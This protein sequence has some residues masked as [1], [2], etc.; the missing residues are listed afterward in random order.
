MHLL[1]DTR[2]YLAPD[3]LV[4]LRVRGNDV[5]RAHDWPALH[6]LAPQLRR[7][8]S[9]WP[10]TWG[11]LCAVAAREVGDPGAR[12]LLEE[13]IAAGFHQPELYADVLESAFG[14]DPD[15]PQ[16]L[17]RMRDNQPAPQITITDWPC[18]TPS[19]PLALFR[20]SE[21]REALLRELVPVPRESA[22]ETVKELLAW[23]ARR[24]RHADA[25]MEVDD[26]VLCLQRVEAGARFA[27]V[28]YSLVLAQALNA[29]GIP[30]RRVGLRQ[31]DYHAGQGRGHVICEAWIDDVGAWVALDAQNGLF[32]IDNAG[33]ATGVRQ[34]HTLQ[35]E[36]G[37][38]PVAV[39]CTEKAFAQDE[40]DFW[41]TYFA[42]P[43]S[44]AGAFAAEAYVPIFQREQPA[45]TT[46]LEREPQRLYPDLSEVDTGVALLDGAL[47][48]HFKAAHPFVTGFAV[49][50]VACD[51][52]WAIDATPGQHE[53]T[54]RA[55]ARYGPLRP[56][57]VSYQVSGA[58]V[59]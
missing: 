50:G 23:V 37:P 43:E 14:A 35:R 26:A 34:L 46:R 54:V 22:W 21:E 51:G 16:L 42:H 27:C 48:L 19:A 52:L 1:L 39:V 9:M 38:T 55:V 41:F 40:L 59:R 25:H 49:D 15:W 44:P 56:H 24:W 17:E 57:R 11:L 2:G 58:A 29:L 10:E 7:D 3:W 28:E 4:A 31:A 13:V 36:G 33:A 45:L 32:W 6:E 8:E 53:I 12:A 5:S 18:I 47:A 30:A 20:L